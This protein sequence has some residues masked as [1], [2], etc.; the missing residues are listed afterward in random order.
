MQDALTMFVPVMKNMLATEGALSKAFYEKCGKGAAPIIAE[1]MGQ[2]GARQAEIYRKMMLFKGMRGV[3]ILFKMMGPM[4]QVGVEIGEVTDE[5]M[6][7]QVSQCPFGIE[8]TSRELC[9]AMR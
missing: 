4:M 8:G 9:E 1:I 7:I 6:H 5:A 3:S 2:S